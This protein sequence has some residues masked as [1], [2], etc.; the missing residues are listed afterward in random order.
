MTEGKEGEKRMWED[1]ERG[2]EEIDITADTLLPIL[3]LKACVR[4]WFCH[5]Y[6]HTCPR[7]L[8]DCRPSLEVT[9]CQ[10][11]METGIYTSSSGLFAHTVLFIALQLSL[12]V[13]LCICSALWKG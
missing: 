3:P 11:P 4:N 6:Y 10:E 9:E 5:V 7:Q 8:P 13:R 1:M 2:S 12:F